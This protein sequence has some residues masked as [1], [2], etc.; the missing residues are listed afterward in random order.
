MCACRPSTTLLLQTWARLAC[1][2]T[3]SGLLATTSSPLRCLLHSC[4]ATWS[5]PWQSSMPTQPPP[6]AVWT[7]Q[8]LLQNLSRNQMQLQSLPAQTSLPTRCVIYL[9]RSFSATHLVDRAL[10]LDEHILFS[11]HLLSKPCRWMQSARPVFRDSDADYRVSLGQVGLPS[12]GS[13]VFADRTSRTCCHSP[14]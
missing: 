12:K 7:Y 11:M 1:Q 10:C 5:V 2:H 3:A 9:R 4:W 6:M 8:E 14:S 13:L